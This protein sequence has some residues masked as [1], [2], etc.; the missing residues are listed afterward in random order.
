MTKTTVMPTT[1]SH[2][3]AAV[4]HSPGTPLQIQTFAWP[5]LGDGEA[6]VEITCCTLCGSDFHSLQGTRPVE[7]PMVLGHEIIGRLVEV[8]SV[9]LDINGDRLRKGDRVGW[10]VAASCD[11]CFF[12]NEGI[13]QKCARLVKFGHQ[14]VNSGHPLSGGLA[15]H[16]HLVRGT[17]IVKIPDEIPDLVACPASCATATVAAALRVAGN[18]C[19][20]SV[21]IFGAGM[22]GLTA[23]AMA[24]EVG[25]TQ[26]F[27]SD[28]DP[29]R[30]KLSRQFGGTSTDISELTTENGGRGCDVAMEMSGATPAIES[31][32]S[33]LRTGGRLVLVGSVFPG[34]PFPF[35]PEQIVRRLLRIEGIHNYT[36]K[37]LVT[38]VG[39]LHRSH[40]LF[41][42]ASLV[43][44]E[45]P[46]SDVN[47]AIEEAKKNRPIRVAIRP[48]SNSN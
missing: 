1:L 48:N 40:R 31:A 18:C 41:P 16:C 24:K 12:C 35:S 28:P 4:F 6:V 33:S 39:F 34:D 19:G 22:L 45:Y 13:P 20:K 9:L 46:L 42:F 11:D 36:P 29:M 8:Q 38:A 27:V 21:A 3:H 26:I 47:L 37:D 14:S 32:L 25:A 23:V 43:S 15:T 44:K 2:P 7:T 5:K 30:A 17:Q 10:S